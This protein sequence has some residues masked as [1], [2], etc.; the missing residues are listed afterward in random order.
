ML[1]RSANEQPQWDVGCRKSSSYRRY[2]PRAASQKI[3][4]DGCDFK[5]WSRCGCLRE[6]RHQGKKKTS[7]RDERTHS[8]QLSTPLRM[9]DLEHSILISESHRSLRLCLRSLIFG[10]F[11][12]PTG[13]KEASNRKSG[14]AK[15]WRIAFDCSQSA[16]VEL[17]RQSPIKC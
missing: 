1:F 11:P 9:L 2:Q 7:D 15:T 4:F 16:K 3:S 17:G 14:F 8:S 6:S 5:F 10:M 12:S 13:Q